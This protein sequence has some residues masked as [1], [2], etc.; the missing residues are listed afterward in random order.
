MAF[1]AGQPVEFLIQPF[2]LLVFD[3]V[4]SEKK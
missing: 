2:E 4:A 3:A 1:N